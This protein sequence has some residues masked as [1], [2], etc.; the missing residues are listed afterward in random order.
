MSTTTSSVLPP[1]DLWA[2]QIAAY[3]TLPDQ[4][5]N[6]RWA[7]VLACLA[8]KPSDSIPQASN[9][10]SQAKATYRFLENDRIRPD[11][12]LQSFVRGT[13]ENARGLATV[14]VIHDS[15]S[16]NY[17]SLKQTTGLGLLNDLEQA[18]GIHLHTSLAL[19]GDGIALGLL[20]QQYWVRPPGEKKPPA[21]QR[22]MEDRESY[23]W[24][25]GVRATAT[26]FTALPV[27]ERPHLVHVMDREGDILAVLEQVAAQGDSAVIRS[28]QNRKVEGEPGLAHAAV[29]AA[30]VLGQT[31]V[32]VKASD[33]QPGREAKLAVRSVA[34]DLELTGT[35]VVSCRPWRYNLVEVR[36][37]DY[38]GEVTEPLHWLLWT[39]EP[40]ATL[41]EV[42]RVLEIYRLRPRVE[43]FHLT[44]KSGCQ[45]ER[46]ELETA[47][48]LQKALVTY[49]GIA[50]RILSLRDLARQE[51]QG[52]CTQCLSEE[53]WQVLSIHF[54]GRIPTSRTPPPTME[55]VV[56]WLGRLGGHMG[57]KSDGMPGV[58]TLWRGWRDLQL[59]VVGYRAGKKEASRG[60]SREARKVRT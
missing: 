4:R 35:P 18:R 39:L 40:A 58:R 17:S 47:E 25:E 57:R 30:P 21:R 22:P 53:E 51:P 49:S 46:L 2:T 41:A 31:T 33:K 23:K 59:L 14:Y 8:A 50:V 56:K 26:A 10:P 54:T 11:V 27:P 34:L 28:C 9:Q 20:H 6:T 44:L 3:A 42:E 12:L 29:Q 38:P 19:R 7:N 1:V 13:V 24:L 36:E 32:T 55:Q 15:T 16:F 48:R 60:R 37:I 5:L 43:D 45:V 52:P